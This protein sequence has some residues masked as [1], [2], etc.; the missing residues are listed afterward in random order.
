MTRLLVGYDGSRASGAALRTAGVL[1]AGAQTTI[2]AVHLPQAAFEPAVLA[3][4]G[5]PPAAILDRTLDDSGEQAEH[6]RELVREGAELA[7]AAGLR[8]QSL[9]LAG[10]HPAKALRHAALGAGA[11]VI[12]CGTRGEGPLGRGL[13]GSTALSLAHHAERALLVVP[14][15]ERVGNGPLLAG[16][17]G[18]YGARQALRFAAR[19]VPQR[20][21]LVA[22]VWDSP[23]RHSL[24][25]RALQHSGVE[26]FE[27]YADTIDTIWREVAEDEAAEGAAF[28]RDQGLAADPIAHESARGACDGLLRAADDTDAL[29]ILVG[30]RGRGALA[31]AVL[32]SVASGLVHRAHR[33][34]LLVPARGAR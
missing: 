19:H 31:S 13:L 14:A 25:G 1:F 6:A 12:V 15:A 21:V 9:V 18:S 28:A 24:R 16:Y 7:A 22:N 33:P 17:D 32:G 27:E 5:E 4:A 23:V 34:I 8:A 10:T 3:R 2:V 29:A 20:R 11:D 26:F 30:T